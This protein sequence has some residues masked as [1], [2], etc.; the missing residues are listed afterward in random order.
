VLDRP[1]V[2]ELPKYDAAALNSGFIKELCGCPTASLMLMDDTLADLAEE[3]ID[4]I[5]A[6]L[7]S[8]RAVAA[9]LVSV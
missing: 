8:F 7:N 6:G 1:T 4:N 9:R 3:I 2:L 5:E